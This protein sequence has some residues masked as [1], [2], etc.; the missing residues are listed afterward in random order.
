MKISPQEA[1]EHIGLRLSDN[2]VISMPYLCT[3][4]NHVILCTSCG[5]F[6]VIQQNFVVDG[7]QY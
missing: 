3:I 2:Q 4:C 5:M 1:L 6:D 7:V